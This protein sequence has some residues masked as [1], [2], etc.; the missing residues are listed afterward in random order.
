[1]ASI[2]ITTPG[3]GLGNDLISMIESLFNYATAVFAASSSGF[4]AARSRSASSAIT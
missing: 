1:M 3:G 4:A 2:T